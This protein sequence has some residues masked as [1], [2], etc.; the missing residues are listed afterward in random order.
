MSWTLDDGDTELVELQIISE[1]GRVVV[2]GSSKV[3]LMKF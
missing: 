1:C 3:R 2:V